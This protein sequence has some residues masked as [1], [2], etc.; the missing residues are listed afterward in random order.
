MLYFIV[1]KSRVPT[2]ILFLTLN[3]L[4]IAYQTLQDTLLD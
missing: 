1:L 3:P 4:E 2:K